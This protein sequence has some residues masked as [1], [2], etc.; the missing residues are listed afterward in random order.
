MA[1]TEKE[2]SELLLKKCRQLLDDWCDEYGHEDLRVMR[3]EIDDYFDG[4]EECQD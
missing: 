1:D 3:N 2:K 4:D